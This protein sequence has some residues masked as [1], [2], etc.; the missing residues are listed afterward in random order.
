MQ[1][2][3][4]QAF[5]YHLAGYSELVIRRR[6][7][8]DKHSNAVIEKALN[9]LKNINHSALPIPQITCYYENLPDNKVKWWQNNWFEDQWEIISPEES[10]IR[11]RMAILL[12]HKVK[13]GMPKE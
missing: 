6:L 4:C 7:K 8:E 1:E 13:R 5:A 10:E 9:E 12:Y 2:A 3:T 11:Q